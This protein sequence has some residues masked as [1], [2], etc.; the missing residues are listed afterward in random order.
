MRG[1]D[2]KLPA[3]C[4]AAVDKIICSESI[5]MLRR[6]AHADARPST[7]LQLTAA[8]SGSSLETLSSNP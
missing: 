6:V 1:Y 3:D 8:A 4:T 7:E 5:E 2:I